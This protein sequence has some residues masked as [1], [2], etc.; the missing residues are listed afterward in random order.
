MKNGF[1]IISRK[2]T[3]RLFI[4]DDIEIMVTDVRG[5]EIDLAIKAPKHVKI[6]RKKS[7]MTE[8]K[9]KQRRKL[10]RK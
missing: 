6:N 9:E 10:I 3:E 1:L 4:G 8:E 2:I 7:Y 5:G